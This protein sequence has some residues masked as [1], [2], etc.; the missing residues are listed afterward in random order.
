MSTAPMPRPWS[1]PAAGTDLTPLCCGCTDLAANVFGSGTTSVPSVPV[2]SRRPSARAAVEAEEAWATAPDP[3]P[4]HGGDVG[5]HGDVEP[6]PARGPLPMTWAGAV[7]ELPAATRGDRAERLRERRQVV[8]AHVE[9]RARRRAGTG[10]P[11]SG[12][13]DAG[14][15]ALEDG[16]AVSGVPMAPGSS[17]RRAVWRP[18]PEERVRGVADP[19]PVR[20]RRG[21]QR[22]AVAGPARSASRSTL[23]AGR[24]RRQRDVGMGGGH[25]E[26]DDQLHV[27]RPSACVAGPP[28]GHP[29]RG[30]LRARASASRSATARTSRSGS[31]HEVAQVLVAD[32][33]G[34]DD[35]D[36]TG[37]GPFTAT[38]GPCS[39]PERCRRRP[40]TGRRA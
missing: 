4:V 2:T 19:Q 16:E 29:V 30:G 26:V 21:E 9:Q 10:S 3:E 15:R 40:G 39:Q 33:A 36:P 6:S 38:P 1:P 17:S 14:P 25:G 23:L 28:S 32:L 37:P 18:G 7:R 27:V 31:G 22:A 34:A 13:R 5:G 8:R 24:D 35:A 11:G 12:A 20:A